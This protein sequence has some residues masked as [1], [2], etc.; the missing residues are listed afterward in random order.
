MLCSEGGS[1]CDVVTQMLV[2]GTGRAR[3]CWRFGLRIVFYLRS[4]WQLIVV[5]PSKSQERKALLLKV[6]SMPI[7][8]FFSA[9][10][11]APPAI[12]RNVPTPCAFPTGATRVFEMQLM[13]ALL[14][15][16]KANDLADREPMEQQGENSS[17]T[18]ADPV[19]KNKTTFSNEAADGEKNAI[20]SAPPSVTPKRAA[21]TAQSDDNGTIGVPQSEAAGGAVKREE[22]DG[23]DAEMTAMPTP[24]AEELERLRTRGMDWGVVGV[25]CCPRSCDVSCEECVVVQ[26]PV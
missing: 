25:W 2:I 26:M 17:A 24:S 5:H 8:P 1:L 4:I 6:R 19:P 16:L 11:S 21:S 14:L 23:E 18:P 7:L 13:P 20:N 10:L 3:G 15:Q 22:G 12:V 9:A